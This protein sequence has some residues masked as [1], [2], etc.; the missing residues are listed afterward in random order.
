VSYANLKA[1]WSRTDDI[2]RREGA[3]AYGR[4]NALLGEIAAHYEFGMEPTVAAFA[5]LSPNNDYL[6]N[7]RSLVSVL[8]GLRRGKSPD[9]I[10]VSTYK[11]CRNR[12]I[13]YATGEV[14][15]RRTVKGPKIRAFYFNIL[16]P[17]D[18]KHVTIDGHMA[19]C[20]RANSGTMKDNLVTAREY[21][22]ITRAVKR[23][24]SRNGLLPNQMQATLWFTRKRLLNVIYDGQYDLF[25]DPEDRWKTLTKVSNIRPY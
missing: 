8:D 3:L 17:L 7:L 12:A 15:F 6:G 5:A 14:S 20:Y 22:T 9:E 25:G 11:A 10:T 4:Y 2:D 21:R 23:L 19:A 16:D 18:R 13:T 24:A 1:M